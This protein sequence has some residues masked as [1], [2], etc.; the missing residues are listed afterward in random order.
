[1]GGKG[2]GVID[3]VEVDGVGEMLGGGGGGGREGWG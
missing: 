2:V 3:V 1:M